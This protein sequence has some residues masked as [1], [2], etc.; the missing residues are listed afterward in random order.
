LGSI[1][2]SGRSGLG[3]SMNNLLR[4]YK[5]NIAQTG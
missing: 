3:L 1:S 2:G 5:L 4:V